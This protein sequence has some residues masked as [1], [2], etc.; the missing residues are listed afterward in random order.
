MK[1]LIVVF[2]TMLLFAM[3]A[4]AQQPLLIELQ[5]PLNGMPS[6]AGWATFPS[7]A[8]DADGDGVADLTIISPR[9]PATGQATLKVKSGDRNETWEYPLTGYID[10]LVGWNFLGFYEL[11]T[12]GALKEAVFAHK[13]G[14][15]LNQ[16]VVLH[17]VEMAQMNMQF[18]ASQFLM[19]IED[20]DD[21]GD[22]ELQIY[23]TQTK[24]LELWG[25]GAVA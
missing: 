4:N 18:L 14:R 6:G 1:K 22:L 5:T 23:N 7:S 25:T 2:G 3:T 8:R 20:A 10:D 24:M 21:D 17:I 15:R 13:Q 19:D 11:N 9:D 16:P 12:N